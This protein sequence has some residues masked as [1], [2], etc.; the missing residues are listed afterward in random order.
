MRMVQSMSLQPIRSETTTQLWNPQVYLSEID[1]D[2]VLHIDE[3][4][5]RLNL[6]FSGHSAFVQFIDLL[7]ECS[8]QHQSSK[9]A[10]DPGSHT[11][12][13]TSP[14]ASKPASKP[15]KKSKP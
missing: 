12:H 3:S 4:S 7:A 9:Q 13:V 1:G 6:A 11:A 5:L 10:T 14:S 2:L 15:S 8:S